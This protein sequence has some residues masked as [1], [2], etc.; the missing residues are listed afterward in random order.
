M[1]RGAQ[2]KEV[3]NLGR[4]TPFLKRAIPSIFIFFR[5]YEGFKNYFC[6]F[7]KLGNMEELFRKN[8]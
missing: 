6:I 1:A 2:N 4:V 3:K 8:E 7:R 5:N